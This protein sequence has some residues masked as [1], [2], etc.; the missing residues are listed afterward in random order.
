MRN[1]APVVK[2]DPNGVGEDRPDDL[3]HAAHAEEHLEH[4]HEQGHHGADDDAY[5]TAVGLDREE[6]EDHD[7]GGGSADCLQQKVTHKGSARLLPSSLQQQL[8]E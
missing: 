3:A 7:V 5:V 1:A 2:P 8:A 6:E 4:A